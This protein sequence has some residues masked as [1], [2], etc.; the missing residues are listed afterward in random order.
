[1]SAIDRS[2][3]RSETW[4]NETGSGGRRDVRR[5]DL[6][7]DFPA[8][9]DPSFPRNVHFACR[10]NIADASRF[11]RSLVRQAPGGRALARVQIRVLHPALAFDLSGGIIFTA[12]TAALPVFDTL[13][14]FVAAGLLY[15]CRQAARHA[16]TS[17]HIYPAMDRFYIYYM[18]SR[19]A[20][21]RAVWLYV[22]YLTENIFSDIVPL[23]SLT[24][25]QGRASDKNSPSKSRASERSIRALLTRTHTCTH[26]HTGRAGSRERPDPRRV[27]H[28]CREPRAARTWRGTP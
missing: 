25:R 27:P 7:I 23:K 5:K 10:R 6:G 20:P 9:D 1:V 15:S 16:H 28:P 13:P 8:L 22:E 21:I 3:F 2:S 17:A 24:S 11:A 12:F 19:I 4:R 26:M 14:P 18:R